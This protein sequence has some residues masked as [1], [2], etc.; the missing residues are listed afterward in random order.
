[1]GVRWRPSS[2]TTEQGETPG[3]RSSSRRRARAFFWITG[4]PSPHISA[5]IGQ[6]K[7]GFSLTPLPGRELHERNKG[8]LGRRRIWQA[9]PPKR[10]P[11]EITL[12]ARDKSAAQKA[13]CRSQRWNNQWARLYAHAVRCVRWDQNAP[14]PAV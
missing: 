12:V 6:Y 7:S 14:A 8:L 10:H 9:R 1:M 11:Q 4:K 3:T 2:F 13:C 5:G